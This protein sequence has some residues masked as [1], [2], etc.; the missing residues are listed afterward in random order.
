MVHMPS[1]PTLFGTGVRLP[2]MTPPKPATHGVEEPCAWAGCT[3]ASSNAR[4][5]SRS[6]IQPRRGLTF[7]LFPLVLNRVPLADFSLRQGGR[8]SPSLGL[9]FRQSRCR[10]ALGGSLDR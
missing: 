1:I 5:S 8:D 2:L 3:P 7:V 6:A 10:G 4:P 9:E